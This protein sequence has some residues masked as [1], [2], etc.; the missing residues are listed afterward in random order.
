M[1]CNH[2][3]ERQGPLSACSRCKM[4]SY[5]GRAH[6]QADFDAHKRA[7]KALTSAHQ[8]VE[9]EKTHLRAMED[10]FMAP[11]DLF[12][13]Q[14]GRFWGIYETRPY[15]RARAAAI[16]A[17]MKIG[18]KRAV[19]EA[20]A[21]VLDCLRLCRSDNLGLRDRAPAMFLRLGKVQECYDFVKWWATC[22]PHGT[23]D[24]GDMELPY[25]SIEGADMAEDLPFGEYD[26]LSHVAGAAM[27]KF[28]L[29]DAI[30]SA[31]AVDGFNLPAEARERI[32]QFLPVSDFVERVT[33]PAATVRRLKTQ[34]KRCFQLV[35]KAN[36]NF[37]PG[38]VNPASLLSLPPPQY[39]SRGDTNEARMTL[40][41]MLPLWMEV[42]GAMA[43]VRS[44]L[45]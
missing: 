38:L 4:V 8:K 22:D 9:Q 41:D 10:E 36:A 20:L 18:T 31:M 39:F 13:T 14:V 37:W 25:L 6:Q 35:T 15:M 2:C 32:K 17:L 34:L 19:G 12:E 29:V 42:D 40:E 44:E 26:S 33:N 30:T 27:V 16:D 21:D 7:C 23:Y 24:W 28:I 45:K 11:E 43:Y 5:C 1:E 3:G